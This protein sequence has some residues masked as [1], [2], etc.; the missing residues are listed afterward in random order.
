MWLGTACCLNGPFFGSFV[1][2]MRKMIQLHVGSVWSHQLN[3][4]V[5]FSSIKVEESRVVLKQK[6]VLLY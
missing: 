1:S 2:V 3:E 4:R 6:I 5:G